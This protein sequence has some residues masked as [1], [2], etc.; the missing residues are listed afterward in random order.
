[1]NARYV[2]S[3]WLLLN[4]ACGFALVLSACGGG[5]GGGGGSKSSAVPVVD[6]LVSATAGAGGSIAPANR[7]VVSGQTTTFTLASNANYEVG[8]ASGCNGKLEGNTYTTGAVTQ[9]CTIDVTFALKSY[10]L[11][12]LIEGSGSITPTALTVHH[13]D[14]ARFSIAEAEGHSFSLAQGCDG[15]FDYT[16]RVYI[17]P[18]V[19]QACQLNVSFHDSAYVYFADAA[20]EQKVRDSLGVTHGE[21]LKQTELDQLQELKA[22]FSNIEHLEGLEKARNLRTAM[23]DFNK[24]TNISPLAGL[25]LR[26]LALSSNPIKTSQMA[27]LAGMP[28]EGLF[29]DETKIDDISILATKPQLN[30][31]SFRY[32]Q[33]R[34]LSPLTGLSQLEILS[35]DRTSVVDL[36][37]TLSLPKLYAL[38]AGGCL[39]TQGFSRALQI[40]EQLEQRG[41]LV[42]LAPPK[43]WVNQNCP[44][45][46]AINQVTLSG[47]LADGALDLNWQI[48]ADNTGPWLCEIHFNLDNQQPRIPSKVIENCQAQ[49]S[50]RL[51]GLN[52]YEYEPYLV[53]DSGLYNDRK[54]SAPLRLTSANRPQTAILQSYDWAQTLLKTNPLL[55]ADKAATLRLHVT[56]Q[57]SVALPNVQVFA[58]LAGQREAVTVTPPAGQLPTS[59]Q[60]GERNQSFYSTIPAR[61]MQPGMK[62]EVLLN[63][64]PQLQ[65][66][67]AFAQVKGINLMLVPIQLGDKVSALP[68]EDM[69]RRSITRFWPLS[70]VHI[71]QR[72]PYQITTPADQANTTTMLYELND[73]RIVENGAPYYYGY[74]DPAFS[75]NDFFIG[76]GF[77]GGMVA[78]GI[79]SATELDMTLAHEMGHSFGLQ[80]APCGTFASIDKE[81]PYAGGITGS[82]STNPD[83]TN[84]YGTQMKDL[85][86]YCD[87]KQVSDYHYEKAQDYLNNQAGQPYVIDAAT[88]RTTVQSRKLDTS[89]STHPSSSLYLRISVDSA[90]AQIAQQIALPH[91]PV[92]PTSSDHSAIVEF[93]DGHQQTL[94]VAALHFSHEAKISAYQLQLLIPTSTQQPSRLILLKGEKRLLKHKFSTPAIINKTGVATRSAKTSDTDNKGL[95]DQVQYRNNEVC[96][97]RATSSPRPANLLWH[98]TDGVIALALNETASHFCRVL[99]NLPA[100]EAEL[101]TF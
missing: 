27:F 5:G 46:D 25:S 17:I 12:T 77:T 60:Q 76:A 70:E 16:K 3:R 37:P 53:V 100:G 20:L 34:D 92:L 66:T 4:I 65:L 29:M 78:V 81:Y 10:Q 63:N 84:I 43:E 73:L 62:L 13:G 75:N 47:V 28:L 39:K 42:F 95:Q 101:Q 64:I 56:A 33:V 83:Y 23:L 94:P 24:I 72:A 49:D 15:Y 31:L 97:A 67:P 11:T 2:I 1:M 7:R 26:N 45:T 48:S 74:F 96:V 93:A 91:L 80:H 19:T 41:V 59:K 61:L 21:P 79:N 82:Y 87:G 8:G 85:M 71:T 86:G 98:H 69:V 22:S 54:V 57:T 9:N 90:G 55:V 32:T 50:L 35:A 36:S 68:D 88:A 44:K 14:E 51:S 89:R 58:E 6:F 40:K 18:S 52:L 30:N 38:S 99:S